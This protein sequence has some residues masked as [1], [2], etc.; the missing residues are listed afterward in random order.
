[1]RKIIRGNQKQKKKEPKTRETR[2]AGK[3]WVLSWLECNRKIQGRFSRGMKR[4]MFVNTWA[5]KGSHQA[6]NA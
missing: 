5:L 3:G 6:V 1:M 2:L 4:Q